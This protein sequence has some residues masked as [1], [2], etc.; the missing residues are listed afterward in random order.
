MIKIITNWVE[1]ITA[2][3][4]FFAPARLVFSI[5]CPTV[6]ISVFKLEAVRQVSHFNCFFASRS[7]QKEE[8]GERRQ[9][10]VG[11][12]QGQE[13]EEERERGGGR[14][15]L[16][17]RRQRIRRRTRR[18]SHRWETFHPVLRNS[19]LLLNRIHRIQTEMIPQHFV[20]TRSRTHNL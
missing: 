6:L 3:L 16:R 11:S 7:P 15:R 20:V 14:S 9:E 17:R 4:F 1:R 18:R 2:F 10:V 5:S 8:V 12:G 13:G 19:N